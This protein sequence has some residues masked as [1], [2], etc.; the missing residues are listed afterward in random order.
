MRTVTQ[1][2]F[3]AALKADKRDIMPSCDNEHYSNWMTRD[4]QVWGRAFPGWKYPA[5]Q[6]AYM[7][8]K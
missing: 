2:E 4:R 1:D 8:A 3:F 7:L 6:E 5:E